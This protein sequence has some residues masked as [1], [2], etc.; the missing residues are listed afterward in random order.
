MKQEN[1]F[2]YILIVICIVAA[3]YF[4]IIE[5]RNTFT[6]ITADEAIVELEND[7]SIVLLDVR[8]LEEYQEK[9]IPR[10]ILMPIDDLETRV[11]NEIDK[12]TRIFV[13]CG[14][15]V[16]SEEAVKILVNLGYANVYNLGGIDDWQ[17]ETESG[18]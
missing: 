2:K 3:I 4:L 12:E 8:T 1:I 9:R 11:I 10:S 7:D 16:R 18:P 15:G 14:T 17:Y 6:N 13:Y 5:N